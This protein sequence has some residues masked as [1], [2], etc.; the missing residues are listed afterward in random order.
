MKT[1]GR[2]LGIVGGAIAILI[3]LIY[4]FLIIFSIPGGEIPTAANEEMQQYSEDSGDVYGEDSFTFDPGQ[5]FSERRVA[6]VQPNVVLFVALLGL[7]LIGGILG[8]IG[9]IVINKKP[10]LSG[11]FLI[12]GA[13]FT[14][15]FILPMVLMVIAAVFAWI[16]PKGTIASVHAS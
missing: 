11:V 10:V 2:V 13:V 5:Y 7:G 15:L 12:I 1:A 8:L 6:A 16:K 4:S 3:A 9:G 14:A